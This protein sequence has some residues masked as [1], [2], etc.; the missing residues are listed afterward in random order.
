MIKTL[1]KSKLLDFLL[2]LKNKYE[3]FIPTNLNDS[4]ILAS[5]WE[6]LDDFSP[7]QLSSS[8]FKKIFF[9]KSHEII[10]IKNNNYRSSNFERPIALFGIN[11]YDLQ[12]LKILDRVFRFDSYWQKKRATSLIIGFGEKSNLL[13]TFDLFFEERK[14]FFLVTSN[15]TLGNQIIKQRLFQSTIIKPK[16]ELPIINPIFSDLEELARAIEKSK[17]DKIWDN[18]ANICFGC[19]A[20]SYVCPLCYCFDIEDIP[21]SCQEKNCSTCFSRKRTWTSCMLPN[22]AKTTH[23]NYRNKL[24]DR[25]YNWY[26]HKF[27]RFPRE[28]GTIG[29][30]S[31]GRCIKECPA[32]I[33]F[34]HVLGQILDKYHD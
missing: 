9:P 22:F 19:G 16:K 12:A 34:H 8:S 24:R 17:N 6:N 21:S 7:N 10:T 1:A 25:I 5:D 18:L 15:S 32:K 20:C 26:H 23:F 2:L 28:F 11:D 33:N 30:V 14:S 4:I 27:I 29:C 13:G 3:V 31:C